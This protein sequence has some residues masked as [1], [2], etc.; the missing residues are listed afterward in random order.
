MSVWLTKKWKKLKVSKYYL[1]INFVLEAEN[2]NQN[3]KKK[4]ICVSIW[5][6]SVHCAVNGWGERKSKT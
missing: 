3:M 1:Q 4:K 2:Q 5:V 6:L